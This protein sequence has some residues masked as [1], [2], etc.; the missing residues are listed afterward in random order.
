MDL[1]ALATLKEYES[2]TGDEDTQNFPSFK[3]CPAKVR[4]WY[5]QN[6]VSRNDYFDYISQ[7][8]I[9]SVAVRGGSAMQSSLTI[10]LS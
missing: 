2:R 3:D 4:K 8:R 1:R 5:Q 9:P 6:E 7:G 10:L